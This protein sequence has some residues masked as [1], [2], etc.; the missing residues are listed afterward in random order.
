MNEMVASDQAKGVIVILDTIKK[1]TDL[2]DKTKASQF[3]KV[4][5]QFVM[6]GG[7]VI[8]MAH[9]NKKLGANGK[10]IYGGTSDIVDDFDCAYTIA[11]EE[12]S[13]PAEKIVVFDNIKRR[14]SNPVRV[15]PG[16]LWG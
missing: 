4:I 3:T 14:G 11:T 10:P 5:R 7:T 9:T 12:C 13:N 2:M 8:G 1:F 15:S 16:A 6:K